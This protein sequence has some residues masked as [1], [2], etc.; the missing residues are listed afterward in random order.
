MIVVDTNILAYLYFPSPLSEQVE[1]LRVREPDW[2]APE[3]WK[4][5]FLNVGLQYYRKKFLSVEVLETAYTL[6]V[7]TV[8]TINIHSDFQSIVKLSVNSKCTAYDCEF[9]ALAMRL[10]IP[11]LSYD[12][13]ILTEFPHIAIKPE[14]YLNRP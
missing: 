4:S 1:Q 12:K 14:D 7:E 6:A 13:L 10:E 9:A 5:E 11:L 8:N 3:L 2:F